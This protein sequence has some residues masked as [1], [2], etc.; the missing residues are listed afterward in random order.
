MWLARGILDLV[1]R[2]GLAI[3]IA[4]VIALLLAL[5][6]GDASFTRSFGIACLVVGCVCLLLAPAGSSPSMR[7]GV[8]DP[9]LTSFTPKLI[10]HLGAADDGPRLNPAAVFLLTG[11]A[12]LVCGFAFL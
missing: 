6:R 7:M 1:L 10:P 12:L 4:L 8:N 9:W 2:V 5:V 11:A 3:S